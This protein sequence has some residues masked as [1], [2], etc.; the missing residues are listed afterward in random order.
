V[1]IT[2]IHMDYSKIDGMRH[3]R[4]CGDCRLTSRCRSAACRLVRFALH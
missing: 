1:I 4:A 2:P 3:A